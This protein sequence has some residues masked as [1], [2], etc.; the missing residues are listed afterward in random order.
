VVAP[1]EAVSR[2]AAGG[3]GSPARRRACRTCRCLP[4]P[5]GWPLHTD[6]VDL[7]T[8]TDAG[9]LRFLLSPAAAGPAR[10]DGTLDIFHAGGRDAEVDEVLR[11]I[12]AVRARR[13][14]RSRSPA[15][16]TPIRCWSGR[17]RHASAGASAL[18]RR[19]GHPHQAW[20]LLLRFCDWVASDFAA[21]IC[22]ACCNQVMRRQRRSK[23]P[24]SMRMMLGPA[25]GTR[26]A[27]ATDASHRARPRA[28]SSRRRPPGPRHLP[29]RA[30]PP[31]GGGTSAGRRP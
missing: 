7:D 17:R 4:G 11:R 24:M 5:I 23:R 10:E 20:R 16:R 1:G 30:H 18:D 28:C 27:S 8:P 15:R 25:T 14:T 12:L 22:G 19:A 6:R 3:P 21:G 26:L 29:A 2:L 9:R 31:C 13:S